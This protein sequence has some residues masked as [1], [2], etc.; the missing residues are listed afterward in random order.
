M[1]HG[2]Y[3]PPYPY[4]F[5]YGTHFNP[6]SNDYNEQYG[7]FAQNKL[8]GT[9]PGPEIPQFPMPYQDIAPIPNYPTAPSNQFFP[10]PRPI[11]YEKYD[12]NNIP[13]PENI[14]GGNPV[15]PGAY[16]QASPNMEDYKTKSVQQLKDD[17][18]SLHQYIGSIKSSTSGN[19]NE[20]QDMIPRLENQINELQ[21]I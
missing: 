12:A 1:N 21:G 18:G 14:N 16:T 6:L 8:Y 5:N 3:P 19:Y 4:Q 9:N 13:P 2:M 10:N 20:N 15:Q 11:P 7:N 17:I